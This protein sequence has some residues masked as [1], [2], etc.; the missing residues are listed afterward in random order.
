[1]KTNLSYAF[2]EMRWR[3]ILVKKNVMRS[4]EE[5]GP[6][7]ATEAANLVREGVTVKGCCF[8]T[9]T[10]EVMKS[11]GCDLILCYSAIEDCHL[12]KL[13]I[14]AEA[15]GRLIVRCLAEYGVDYLWNGNGNTEILVKGRSIRK[16]HP[17]EAKTC[18]L[19]AEAQYRMGNFLER[20]YWIRY[21]AN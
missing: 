20:P 5:A 1:M 6:V 14:A 21:S 10:N 4:V 3:G 8:Y 15:V 2:D 9:A 11:K 13:G 19:P 18:K 7:I 16:M 17:C 12:G